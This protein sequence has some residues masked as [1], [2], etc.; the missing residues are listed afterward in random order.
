MNS[1]TRWKGRFAS[2]AIAALFATIPAGVAFAQSGPDSQI[3]ADVMKALDKK[4]F[5]NVHAVSQ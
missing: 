5:Q 1:V 3:Q 4:Q 2:V